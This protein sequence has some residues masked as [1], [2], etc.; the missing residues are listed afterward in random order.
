MDGKIHV[1]AN[2]SHSLHPSERSMHNYNFAKLDLLALKWAVTEK[3][4]DYLLGLWF[5]V[6]M[7]NNLLAYVQDSKLGASQ[8][9][10]LSEL[11][12][13]NFTINY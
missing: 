4:Q 5:Y 12:L 9:Q 13:F 6:Y 11:A 7:E 8:I 1:N 3:L 10:W 2:A